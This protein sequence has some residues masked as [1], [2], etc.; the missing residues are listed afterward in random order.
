[1][2]TEPRVGRANPSFLARTA[3]GITLIACRSFRNL[4]T[5][6]SSVHRAAPAT[7]GRAHRK[8]PIAQL[9]QPW[10]GLI[11]SGDLN[12]TGGGGSLPI[13]QLHQQYRTFPL[14]AATLALASATLALAMAS[15]AASDVRRGSIGP[16]E[17]D[18]ETLQVWAAWA[19]WALTTLF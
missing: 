6:H 12:H 3:G 15:L 1:M 11:G 7:L 10:V 19:A 17:S 9:Q 13:A 4:F 14:A 16:S 18:S 2:H 5:L 8:W